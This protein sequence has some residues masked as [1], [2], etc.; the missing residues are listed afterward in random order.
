[1]HD[2]EEWAV[3][4][5]FSDDFIHHSI[6]GAAFS[7]EKEKGAVIPVLCLHHLEG[8][9]IL[10]YSGI[11]CSSRALWFTICKCMG[12]FGDRIWNKGLV[13][14]NPTGHLTYTAAAVVLGLESYLRPL[15]RG[16]ATLDDNRISRMLGI[17]Q[18]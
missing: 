14:G 13:G 15:W 6:I 17:D 9:G 8:L 5:T 3:D 16:W 12:R 18:G 7:W 11:T 1:M 2:A 10:N 4:R